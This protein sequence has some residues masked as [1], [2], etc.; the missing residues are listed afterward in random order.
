M[1]LS[2][3]HRH[4]DLMPTHRSAFTLVELMVSIALV[5]L[6]V[7]G[8]N[9]VFRI[10][11][12]T[13]G[14]GNALS[15]S[16]ANNRA[17]QTVI[18]NDFQQSLIRS[19]D[20]PAFIIRSEVTSAFLDKK[21]EM[22]D[23]DYTALYVTG[24]T[25]TR[26]QV[27]AALL[28]VDL[29][30]NNREG[31]TTVP[32]EVIPR[33]NLDRRNHRIDL[34]NFFTRYLYPRQTGNDGQ[35]VAEM[36][37]NEAWVWYGILKQPQDAI[38]SH[39]I[40]MDP[41]WNNGGTT[42]MTS[43]PGTAVS[44][45]PN[46]FYARQWGLGRCAI[47]LREPIGGAITDNVPTTL[48]PNGTPQAYICRRAGAAASSLTPLSL[49]ARA[50]TNGADS[51]GPSPDFF[52]MAH[53][54]FDLA[55]TSIDGF[56]T[57]MSRNPITPP[58]TFSI[59]RSNQNWFNGANM[60]FRFAG[61]AFPTTPLSSYGTARTV[62][63]LVGGCTQFIVEFAG[64]YM[65]QNPTTGALVRHYASTPPDPNVPNVDGNTDFIVDAAGNQHIRWYGFPRDVSGTTL[66]TYGRPD[67]TITNGFAS[68]DV[69]PLRDS[70]GFVPPCEH[71]SSNFP[72][73][74][75]NYNNPNLDVFYVA[76]WSPIYPDWSGGA[77]T[78]QAE[79]SDLTAPPKPTMIRVTMVIDDPS[80]RLPE[81]QQYEYV[82]Q[83]P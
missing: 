7:V 64:D 53:S 72:A 13:I 9:G 21:D 24:S 79:A 62:P 47:L 20:M 70:L 15:T 50:T 31:E 75:G 27:D 35:Y 38:G 10:A 5:L 63:W 68:P 40:N 32:G 58:N 8:I 69:L 4:H 33:N 73:T 45:N 49:Q 39:N 18:F 17:V 54:R 6:L 3:Q 67:G 77:P 83:L 76:A 37:S 42:P 22:S 29:D 12:D 14:A 59:L 2:Q 56:R 48:N 43:K 46:N 71:L 25:P 65:N 23:R 28:T 1:P 82:I 60:G 19:S 41:G 44:N 30:G 57:L 16:V 34:M 74:G 55:G 61:Y 52:E 81:G 26:T 51:V 66:A 78:A 36:S 11:T 80:G